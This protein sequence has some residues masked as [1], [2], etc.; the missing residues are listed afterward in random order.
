VQKDGQ[1]LRLFDPLREVGVS[2]DD[3]ELWHGAMARQPHHLVEKRRFRCA[4]SL[5]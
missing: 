4:E 5:G 1:D 2:C 3:L